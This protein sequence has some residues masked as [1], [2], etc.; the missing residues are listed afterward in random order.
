MSRTLPIVVGFTVSCALACAAGCGSGSSSPA[1]PTP[2]AATPQ[3]PAGP[4][5][6]AA[7]LT[8]GCLGWPGAEFS[9]SNKA[10]VRTGMG[11]GDRAV[12][13]TLRDTG[14]GAVTLS[15]LLATR[16]VLLVH[17]AFT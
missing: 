1:T 16:P 13:F 11:A 7:G 10:T 14:G 2:Q 4:P 9:P 8:Q 12:E 5:T 3:T 17:G 15:G 6:L